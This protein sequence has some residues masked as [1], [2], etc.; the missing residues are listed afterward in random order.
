MNQFAEVMSLKHVTKP[1]YVD[2]DYA[3]E[4]SLSH[5]SWTRRS[6]E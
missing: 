5:D 4:N 2:E 3:M 1:N 6:R